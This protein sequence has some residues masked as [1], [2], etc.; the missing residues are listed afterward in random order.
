MNET[1]DIFKGG[2]GDVVPIQ[3]LEDVEKGL[4]ALGDEFARLAAESNAMQLKLKYLDE[5]RSRHEEDVKQ[6]KQASAEM[7]IQFNEIMRRWDT[8]DARMFQ[9]LQQSQEDEKA[10]QKS[11]MDFTKFVLGGTIIAIV[12][13]IFRGG[14]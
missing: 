1:G 14:L 9:L 2:E 12:A 6:I 4:S 13:F 7:K 8:L 10:G 11:W 3:R 5:S